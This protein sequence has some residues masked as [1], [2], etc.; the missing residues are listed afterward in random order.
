MKNI[1]P[2]CPERLN[3]Y[4]APIFLTNVSLR[5]PFTRII[6]SRGVNW[7]SS[8]IS[9]LPTAA[10]PE[11]EVSSVYSTLWPEADWPE[12]SPLNFNRFPHNDDFWCTGV[13]KPFENIVGKEENA[14]N[15]HFL[16]FSQCF[17]SCERQLWCFKQHLICRLQMLPIWA[18]PKFCH[19]VKG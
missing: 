8:F 12:G 1:P 19:L 11:S 3:W 6:S 7:V 15:Q 4:V 5:T 2:F 13:Q 17:L 14:G 16:L 10:P 18:S 9:S